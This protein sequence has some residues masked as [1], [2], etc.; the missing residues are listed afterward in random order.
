AYG[1]D[2]AEIAKKLESL[3]TDFFAVA[4]VSEGISLRKNGVSKPIL[5]LHPQSTH[6]QEIIENRLTPAIY[7]QFVLHEFLK[8]DEENKQKNYPVHLKLN[9]GLNRLGFSEEAL[10]FLVDTFQ[11]KQS[12]KVEG[13]FSHLAA[14][15]DPEEKAFTER[16]IARFEK[17]TKKLVTG[18]GYRPIF[19]LCN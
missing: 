10:D 5:V 16:Q 7:S 19:H 3:G 6:F 4:Y 12:A 17:Y 8:T 13:V 15:E 11:K 2:A 9:T 1:S 14:S 18:L